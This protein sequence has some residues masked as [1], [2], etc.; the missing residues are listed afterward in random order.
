MSFQNSKMIPNHIFL[1]LRFLPSCP[2]QHYK[3]LAAKWLIALDTLLVHKSSIYS[4][5]PGKMRWIHWRLVPEEQMLGFCQSPAALSLVCPFS[6][7]SL[8][9]RR[10]MRHAGPR[11]K[12]RASAAP[13][14]L[15]HRVT[16]HTP[17]HVRVKGR[18][19]HRSSQDQDSKPEGHWLTG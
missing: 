17:P 1:W 4:F 5:T 12:P 3:L 14:C 2:R 7:F 6:A 19:S 16:T 9:A 10:E 15:Q 11:G 18:I 8:D 13:P